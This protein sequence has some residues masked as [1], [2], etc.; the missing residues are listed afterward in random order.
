MAPALDSVRSDTGDLGVLRPT[1]G[2]SVHQVRRALKDDS[3]GRELSEAQRMLIR[4]W[5]ARRQH[6]TAE[7]PTTAALAKSLGVA[8]ST[9][10][11]CIEKQSRYKSAREPSAGTDEKSAPVSDTK[12]KSRVGSPTRLAS[13]ALYGTH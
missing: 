7:N 13:C 4:Q 8:R 6:F 11:S 10:F 2:V 12:F 3:T 1:L 5:N 9:V